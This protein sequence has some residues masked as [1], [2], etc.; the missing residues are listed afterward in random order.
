[1]NFRRM[2]HRRG[3][4]VFEMTLALALVGTSA[5]VMVPCLVLIDRQHQRISQEHAALLEL[6]NVLDEL[7]ACDPTEL[8][9]RREKLLSQLASELPKTFAEAD[10]SIQLTP[11]E[12]PVGGHQITCRLRWKT[13]HGMWRAPLELTGWNLRSPMEQP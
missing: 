8:T 9:Q 1:M 12:Q 6:S 7:T 5:A 13:A 4:T 2:P 10:L 11:I 3:F